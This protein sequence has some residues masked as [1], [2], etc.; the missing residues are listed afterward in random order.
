MPHTHV[1]PNEAQRSE[2]SKMLIL[3]NTLDV[4]PRF[5]A[6]LGMTCTVDAFQ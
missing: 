5:L 2:E 3:T 4:N 6:A 1:I